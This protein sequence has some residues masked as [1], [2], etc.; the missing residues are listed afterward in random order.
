[1]HM[2]SFKKGRKVQLMTQDGQLHD[3][4]LRRDVSPVSDNIVC[5]P[6]RLYNARNVYRNQPNYLAL[7]LS[8]PF[9]AKALQLAEQG[10]SVFEIP[11]R[12]RGDRYGL[13]VSVQENE[14]EM[15]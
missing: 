12:T 2:Y 7:D 6:I 14:S 13:V 15:D 1:M 8:N 11:G 5:D 9:D 10:F 3:Y 4:V